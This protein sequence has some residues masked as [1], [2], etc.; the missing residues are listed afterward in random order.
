MKKNY[1]LDWEDIKGFSKKSLIK[2]G[3]TYARAV[4]RRVEN[5]LASERKAS[6]AYKQYIESNKGAPF[7][8]EYKGKS[9]TM[10]GVLRAKVSEDMPI[11]ELRESLRLFE[12][13]LTAKTSTSEGIKKTEKK[14]LK[15]AK[16]FL[17]DI[18]DIFLKLEQE[19]KISE[20]QTLRDFLEFLGTEAKSAIANKADSDIVV[21]A[22]S[23]AYNKNGRNKNALKEAYE[24]HVKSEK[25]FEEWLR[26]MG[27]NEKGGIIDGTG[28]GFMQM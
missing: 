14:K 18:E 2:I 24:E 22:L 6:A 25:T 9:K 19:N 5:L 4:N 11:E 8:Y 27:Y 21:L 20:E 16:K 15:N 13:F 12:K 10:K 26:K 23:Y 3:N 7:L 1:S 17:G 28:G